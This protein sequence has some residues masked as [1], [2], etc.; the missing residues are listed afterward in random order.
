MSDQLTIYNS[1][2]GH[3][4]ESK[5]IVEQEAADAARAGV[6][7]N[8]SCRYP[9]C[10]EAGVHFKAVYLQALPKGSALPQDKDIQP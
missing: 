7:I 4:T 8:D 5:S 10:S 2:L 1:R 9:F 3:R 6:S